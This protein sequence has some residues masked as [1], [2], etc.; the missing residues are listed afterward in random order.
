VALD[1]FL[2]GGTKFELTPLLCNKFPA[3]NPKSTVNQ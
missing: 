3:T 1:D 2:A